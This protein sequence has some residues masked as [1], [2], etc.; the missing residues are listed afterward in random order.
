MTVAEPMV[1]VATSCRTS[2]FARVI[3]RMARAS[4]TV[5]DIGSPSGTATT[6][7]MTMYTTYRSRNWAT[8]TASSPVAGKKTSGLPVSGS[9]AKKIPRTNR[10]RKMAAAAAYPTLLM[11]PARWDNF[12]CSGVGS[13]DIVSFRCTRSSV[14]SVWSPDS[15][16][17]I[18][19]IMVSSP[20]FET[21]ISP[22]PSTTC[23][24]RY[25]HP[26]LS[27]PSVSSSSAHTPFRTASDSPVISDWS[28]SN[29]F[30]FVSRPSA[31]ISSPVSSSTRSPTTTSSSGSD[32]AR[33]SRLT[34]TRTE[35]FC[36]F[37]FSNSRSE[38]YSDRNATP[39]ARAMAIITASPSMDG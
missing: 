5:T 10:A 2:A 7:T 11:T 6:M 30:A 9:V 29:S 1:S 12:L 34:F 24:P 22:R 13:F 3:F 4:D 32:C 8:A 18:C 26:A 28:R 33:P 15:R 31:G 17:A 19:P 25:T 38:R 20:T 35:S 14:A 27:G 36:E 37:S 21:I 23:V 16:R 39:V